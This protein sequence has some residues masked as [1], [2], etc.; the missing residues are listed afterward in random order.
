MMV[1][2]INKQLKKNIL[3]SCLKYG[4]KLL[5]LSVDI[6]SSYHS[7]TQIFQASKLENFLIWKVGNNNYHYIAY[8]E[9]HQ[10]V[11]SITS[12]EVITDF[13]STRY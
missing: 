5:N 3:D 11:H 10:A 7:A 9:I 12:L 2:Y 1:I 13:V 6:F 4:Y 8:F